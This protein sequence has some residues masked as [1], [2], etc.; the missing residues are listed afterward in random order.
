MKM[1]ERIKSKRFGP[2]HFIMANTLISLWCYNSKIN[3][4]VSKPDI[5]THPK[6]RDDLK[7]IPIIRPL[8]SLLKLSGV[9]GL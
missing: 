6:D 8:I 9:K 5:Y 1:Y 7:E 3:F 2:T 4:L